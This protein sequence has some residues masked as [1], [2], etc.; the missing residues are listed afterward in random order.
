METRSAS[1]ITPELLKKFRTCTDPDDEGD[2]S[3]RTKVPDRQ[4]EPSGASQV[5][6]HPELQTIHEYILKNKLST[7]ASN[8]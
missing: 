8:D 3:R 2:A 6:E 5:Y 1:E 7:D 4:K